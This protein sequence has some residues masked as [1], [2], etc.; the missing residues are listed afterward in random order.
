[1]NLKERVEEM[2]E[3]YVVSHIRDGLDKDSAPRLINDTLKIFDESL[4]KEKEIEAL[5]TDWSEGNN[6]IPKTLGFRYK[7]SKA[8]YK[9]VKSKLED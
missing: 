6:A 7:L 5:L 9:L 4:P 1:M 3:D 8:L 2:L